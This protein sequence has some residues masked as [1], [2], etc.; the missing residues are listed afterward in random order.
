[1]R[2]PSGRCP[3]SSSARGPYIAI[4][5][6]DDSRVYPA[7]LVIGGLA[8]LAALLVVRRPPLG[9]ALA[10][11]AVTLGGAVVFALAYNLVPLVIGEVVP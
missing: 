3:R 4:R 10:A 1:M 6:P 2:S 7:L 11:V 5:L 9:D 8:L